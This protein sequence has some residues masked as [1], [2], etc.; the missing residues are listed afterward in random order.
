LTPIHTPPLVA[1]SVLH[2]GF[3]GNEEDNCIYAKFKN[4]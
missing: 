3:K 4:G 1:S 2:F